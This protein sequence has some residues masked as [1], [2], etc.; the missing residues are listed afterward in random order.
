[1]LFHTLV[2]GL[3]LAGCSTVLAAPSSHFKVFEKLSEIPTG[4][5]R[6]EY[7]PSPDQRIKLQLAVKQEDKHALLEEHL[8]AISTPGHAQYG[9]HLDSDRLDE[10]LRPDPAVSIAIASWLRTG[11][12]RDCDVLDR[13][14]FFILQTTIAQAEKLLDT[15]FNFF[16]HSDP[17]EEPRVRALQY[18]VLDHLHPFIQMIQPTTHFARAKPFQQ[19]LQPPSVDY[20]TPTKLNT[21]FCNSTTTPNCLRAL[22]KL[23]DF[24]ANA[25]SG[26]KF[27]ISGFNYQNAAHKDLQLFLNRYAPSENGSSF[28]VVTS[29]GGKNNESAL[30][31]W[32]SE[33]SM[34][35]QYGV[36]LAPNIPITFYKTGG[37][38]PLIPDLQQPGGPESLDVQ[39]P[40][41]EHL[42]FLL[43]LSQPDLPAVLSVSYG[44]DE[45][46]HPVSY[47]QSVCQLFAR[48]GARGVSVLVS[49]GDGGVGDG[50]MTNDG[51]NTTRFQPQFPASW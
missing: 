7:A 51:K 20:G 46:S 12:I 22:Y 11:G 15:K 14:D 24:R 30:M 2:L 40:F 1:M 35:I 8:L 49:S 17:A 48:L 42:Q 10:L 31:N 47:M 23:G 13:G 44:E 33:A 18:S 28:K 36:S 5:E 4:W 39:E 21:T 6:V 19:L 45:Q 32:A 43:N 27:G 9:N 38:G 3:W 37:N 50:C 25:T 34:D 16:K 41:L 26:T 29:N